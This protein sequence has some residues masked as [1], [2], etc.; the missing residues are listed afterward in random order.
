[1]VRSAS[2]R[3]YM[4]Y[5]TPVGRRRRADVGAGIG[6]RLQAR[7]PARRDQRV[8]IEQHHVALRMQPHAAVHRG[9]K[10][11]V[12]LV[13]QQREASVRRQAAQRLGQT[14]VGA[15]VV[16][17]HEFHVGAIARAEHA[18]D[19]RERLLPSLV[20]R[21]DHIH[22]GQP[23]R[24]QGCMRLFGQ[25]A[26]QRPAL[27]VALAQGF[28]P[29]RHEKMQQFRRGAMPRF[30]L[31]AA[32][33]RRDRFGLRDQFG[34]P[35][36]QQLA[37][38]ERVAP[39][40]W[41]ELQAPHLPGPRGLRQR[42]IEPRP[43]GV[44]GQLER[45]RH[46]RAR[47]VRRMRPDQLAIQP[48]IHAH[49]RQ[50]RAGIGDP[51]CDAPGLADVDAGRQFDAK[52]PAVVAQR[53][54][55]ADHTSSQ[56]MLAS[57]VIAGRHRHPK[58][59]AVARNAHRG[60]VRPRVVG[61]DRADRL[62]IN[63]HFDFHLRDRRVTEH[64]PAA[65][66]DA[67]Q[68]VDAAP[69]RRGVERERAAVQGFAR[70]QIHHVDAVLRL[71]AQ[72][73]PQIEVKPPRIFRSNVRSRRIG[74]DRSHLR[75]VDADPKLGH[76]LRCGGS[77]HPAEDDAGRDAINGTDRFRLDGEVMHALQPPIRTRHPC[78]QRVR[79]AV[80]DRLRQANRKCVTAVAV[81]C[82][83]GFLVQAVGDT[84]RHHD[85]AV[86]QFDAEFAL[87][88]R[89]REHPAEGGT[90]LNA[91]EAADHRLCHHA[92]GA[93]AHLGSLYGTKT[94]LIASLLASLSLRRRFR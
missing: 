8:G 87:Q 48:C 3:M 59:A 46:V 74:L 47:Q 21:N 62:A 33:L 79:A 35:D 64:H 9:D 44:C 49:R 54:V 63:Q 52:R 57:V 75:A 50:R 6:R 36:H 80:R 5:P 2:R 94:I 89:R 90:V 88:G 77:G 13:L 15:L 86:E 22:A 43:G 72:K 70:R 91:L 45:R 27:R 20:H 61:R 24:E 10:A 7:E 60:E 11:Q 39:P 31:L 76:A 82:F 81:G 4:Q 85:L 17:H 18:R 25:L 34:A 93:G 29:L 37:T 73:R 28:E 40:R 1:M 30:A 42:K 14:G 19:A 38:G 69:S 66:L 78:A 55:L 84:F 56:L 65:R 53:Q 71:A 23:P 83:F 41:A 32:Q 58:A 92:Y 26:M 12:A 16:D 68:L 67:L 51:A